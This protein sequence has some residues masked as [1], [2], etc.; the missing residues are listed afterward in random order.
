MR[1]SPLAKIKIDQPFTH[2]GT[3]D[4]EGN[5]T[6]SRGFLQYISDLR[7]RMGADEDAVHNAGM[8]WSNSPS[9]HAWNSDTAGTHEAGN[10]TQDILFTLLDKNNVTIATRTLKGTMTSASGNITVTE[11]GTPTGLSTTVVYDPT[12]NADPTV[13]ATVVVAFNDGSS[14]ITIA[15]WSAVDE[16][17]AGGTPASGGGK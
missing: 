5:V 3:A 2:L 4:K 11:T 1:N 13:K 14:A 16:S 15:T 17:T 8:Q 10:P 7:R 6:A 12:N 9:S